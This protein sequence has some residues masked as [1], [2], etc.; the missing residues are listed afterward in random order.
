MAPDIGNQGVE[1]AS[2]LV[3]ARV[4]GLAGVVMLA[5]GSF[6][7]VVGSRLVVR[8][9]VVAT[10]RNLVASTSLFRLG[11]VS[12]L[13]MMIAFLFYGLLLYRLPRPV[14]RGHALTMVGLVVA[15]VP[16]Y[17]LNQL[18]QYAALLLASEPGRSAGLSGPGRRL[19][20]RREGA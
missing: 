2:P 14:D 8:G 9:D 18:N 7:G 6:A 4:A 17:M 12:G 19:R 1:R 16:I 20:R 11:I 15:S 10:S 13:V 5:C 3:Q